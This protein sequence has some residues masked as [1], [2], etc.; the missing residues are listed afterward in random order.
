MNWIPCAGRLPDM[1]HTS[2]AGPITTARRYS[3]PVVIIGK[4]EDDGQWALVARCGIKD[5]PDWGKA[6]EDTPFWCDE[7]DL[8]AIH[9]EKDAPTHWMPLPINDVTVEEQNS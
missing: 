9:G 8:I 2:D 7:F 6:P 4:N 1:P 5:E 3:D